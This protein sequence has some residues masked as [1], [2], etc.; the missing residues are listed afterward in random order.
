M[1][2]NFKAVCLRTLD[3]EKP[4]PN[5]QQYILIASILKK[6]LFHYRKFVDQKFVTYRTS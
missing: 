6:P 1:A 4:N 2:R 5:A 3:L